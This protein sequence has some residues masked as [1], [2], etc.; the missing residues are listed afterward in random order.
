MDAT[1][2]RIL[3]VDDE[4]NDVELIRSAFQASKA[5][6][7][8]YVA[9]SLREYRQRA[10]AVMPDIALVDLNLPDGKAFD[11]L[12]TPAE[13]GAFPIVIITGQGT[14]QIAV[15]AVKSGALDYVVKSPETFAA[16]PRTVARVLREWAAIREH[17]HAVEELKK[18]EARFS[19]VFRTSPIGIGI[20][21][22]SDGQFIDVNEAF[23]NIHGYRRDEVIGHTS[24]ELRLWANPEERGIMLKK[25]QDHGSVHNFESKLRRKTGE[26]GNLLISAEVIELAGE[27]CLLGMISDVT[28]RKKAEN[29]I[30]TR[31][32]LS[33]LAQHSSLDELMQSALDEAEMLTGSSISFFHFVDADQEVLSLQAWS[34][35]TL[36][37][38]CKAKGKGTHY[39]VSQAGVWADCVRIQQ[40]VIQN[41]YASLTHKKVLPDGHAPVMRELTVPVLR[42]DSV[43]AVMGVGNRPQTY[44][45]DDV[46]TVQELASL[47]MDLVEGKRAEY[48]LRESRERYR[49]L[50][51][52]MLE[53]YAYCK[54][55]FEHKTPVDFIY[56]DVNNAFESLTGLTNV[57][58]KKVSEVIPG[59]RQANPELFEIYGRVSLT[60]RP[61]RFESYVPALGIW[62]SIAV[63]S[64]RKEHFVAV[65]DNVTE[66]KRAESALHDSE[67]NYRTLVDNALVGVFR[68]TSAGRF[69]YLN[70]AMARIFE[71]SSPQEM[72]SEDVLLRHK[73]PKD[74]NEYLD[75]LKLFGKVSNY[76]L[77]GIT[78]SG[79]HVNILVSAA[80]DNEII[81]GMVLDITEHKKL[82]GQFRQAQKMEAIGL[83][84]GGVAHDFNNILTA[85]IGYSHLSLMKLPS[86]DPVRLNLEQILESSNRAAM[87]TQSLLA[88]SRRQPVNLAVIDLN[89]VIKEFEKFI[90]RLIREDI[91]LETICT[92]GVLPIMADRGQIEQVIMNLITNA[93]DAMSQGGKL[94]I[95]TRQIYL[96]RDFIEAHGFGEAGE[97]A[98]V[99]VSD[100]GMGMDEQT[101]SRIFEP[102]FTT[103]EQ[104]KGTGLGLSMVYGTVK[105]HNGYI[106]VYSEPGNGTTV[107][108]Y[109]PLERSAMCIDKIK[110]QDSI[111][112]GGTETILV[113]EDDEAIRKLIVTV[114]KASGYTVIEAVNGADALSRFKENKDNTQL[115]ILDGIMPKMNGKEVFREIKY[116]VPNIKC[117][118]MSGYAEDIFNKDDVS[119][120]DTGFILKPTS[121]A[122]LLMKIREVLDK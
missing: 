20:S 27:Q 116:I 14:E 50:F 19:T 119:D 110:A 53:G 23:L 87:L 90:H 83:L 46:E 86:N 67:K 99:S 71:C 12:T 39:P 2:I 93:R 118:F 80:L 117:I 44:T 95:D 18:S 89:L 73:S 104:D 59:I 82:E 11:L 105:K 115:V 51:E 65:F 64:P 68:S 106:N 102:F 58:G 72:L 31:L 34:T 79:K 120:E 60:G 29:L 8:I 111:V 3:I 54:M 25:L 75:T 77:E 42:R 84:A 13:T 15:E 30:R 22:L 96:D 9:H 24:S 69:L 49:S 52:N 70:E 98:L 1:N 108:I 36:Q 91:A 103:K 97:Y 94:R 62:F 48:A 55:L 21:R 28:K 101:R 43:V 38:M 5:V 57:V 26:V 100:T 81:S 10:A 41:D 88:F 66:R 74:L 121:P 85:I 4:Q 56:F 78:K 33:E 32:R 92:E 7:D 114:L 40:P 17:K 45:Q 37:V 6:I 35:N 109:L 61:E 107:K 76:E 63:Y 16:M 122:D 113:A 47:V 112:R